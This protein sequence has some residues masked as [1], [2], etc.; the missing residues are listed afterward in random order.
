LGNGGQGGTAADP[1]ALRVFQRYFKV[2]SRFSLPG[3]SD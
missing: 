3:A 2:N 1:A